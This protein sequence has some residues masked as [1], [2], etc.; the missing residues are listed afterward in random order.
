LAKYL[1]ASAHGQRASIIYWGK[2]ELLQ[3]SIDKNYYK[4]V[5][6]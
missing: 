3:L 6:V 1:N 2:S 4:I 5:H